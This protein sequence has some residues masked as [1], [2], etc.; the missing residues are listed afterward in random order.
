MREAY[1]AVELA[2]DNPIAQ[3]KLAWCAHLLHR[4]SETE[5]AYRRVLAM[6]PEH[7]LALDNLSTIEIPSSRFVSA[8]H[9]SRVAAATASMTLS[10][11]ATLMFL[12]HASRGLSTSASLCCSSL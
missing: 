3:F 11:G 12:A 9:G 5:V 10:D 4:Y 1:K 6:Q 2:P 8:A 7:A